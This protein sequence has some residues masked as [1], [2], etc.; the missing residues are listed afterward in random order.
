MLENKE[1]SK[2]QLDNLEKFLA[3][4][5]YRKDDLVMNSKERYLEEILKKENINQEKL[6]ELDEEW[7]KILKKILRDLIKFLIQKFNLD[8]LISKIAFDLYVKYDK[9]IS[10]GQAEAVLR[11]VLDIKLSSTGRTQLYELRKKIRRY[12]KLITDFSE[13]AQ[14]FDFTFKIVIMGLNP[15]LT[16]KLL[17]ISPLPH[18]KGSALVLGVELYSKIIEI[19]D[20]Q[21][22]LQ[23]W[24]I[25]GEQKHRFLIQNYCKGAHGAIIVYD[26]RNRE[27]FKLAKEFHSELNKGTNLKFKIKEKKGIY[28]KMPIF[29]IALGEGNMIN[30]EE[31]QTLAKE[32][33][34][35][36]YIEISRKDAEKFE[37][38]LSS[39][40]L[41]IITRIQ[42]ALKRTKY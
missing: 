30:A 42:N 40:S 22:K 12:E 20:A 36:G 14:K 9:T 35:Y 38:I 26:K 24:D 4:L 16:T 31:G 10:Q 33:G 19:Y 28:L 21:V 11:R 41:A 39:L 37:N 13:W 34:A 6:E 8:W 15:E 1:L 3:K 2:T 29:L 5:S 17:P 27:S 18:T 32:W 7:N 25:S 23:L